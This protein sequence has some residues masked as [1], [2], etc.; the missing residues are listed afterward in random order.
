MH[1]YAFSFERDSL[2]PSKDLLRDI[3]IFSFQKNCCIS[4]Y[5]Y[6][7]INIWKGIGVSSILDEGME[8]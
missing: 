8:Y 6:I 3:Y 4:F 2:A 5:I 7:Y 1:R